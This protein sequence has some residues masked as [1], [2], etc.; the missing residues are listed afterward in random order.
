MFEGHSSKT[1]KKSLDLLKNSVE[2]LGIE[3][4]VGIY[5]RYDKVND[6]DSFNTAI[7]ESKFNKNLE[8][9]TFV[10]GI[11]NNKLPKFMVNLGWKPMSIISLTSTFKNNK[12][13]VY[14]SDVDLTIFYTDKQPLGAGIDN[15]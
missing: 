11:S 13:S 9:T 4:S 7:A 15:L 5:F 12:S 6:T 2:E 10:A 1:D 3:N 14:F 8:D